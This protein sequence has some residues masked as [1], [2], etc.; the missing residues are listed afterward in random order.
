SSRGLSSDQSTARG[1]RTGSCVQERRSS[2]VTLTFYFRA[3]SDWP[4]RSTLR[5]IGFLNRFDILWSL[6]SLL[7]SSPVSDEHAREIIERRKLPD[8]ERSCYVDP[9]DQGRP[10]ERFEG[11]RNPEGEQSLGEAKDDYERIRR[12][13]GEE[14]PVAA[15][16]RKENE[17]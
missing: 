12:V 7:L 4:A 2:A 3:H 6:L 9:P 17:E 5:Q 11:V 13:E 14:L 16:R 1:F 15:D 8:P 10:R